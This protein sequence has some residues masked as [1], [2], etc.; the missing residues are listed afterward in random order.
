MNFFCRDK[1]SKNQR[2]KGDW[3]ELCLHINPNP[4]HNVCLVRDCCKRICNRDT[5]KNQH[6]STA[7]TTTTSTITDFAFCSTEQETWEKR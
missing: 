7:E 1:R 5:D 2:R 3:Y 4:A 6:I